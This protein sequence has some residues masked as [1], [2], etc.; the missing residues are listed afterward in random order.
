MFNFKLHKGFT[1]LETVIALAVLGM[2]FAATA[3][4]LQQV[5]V[6]IGQS[7]LQ[8]TA[9]SLGQ[10]KMETIRNLPYS[11]VGT[12][13][14]IPQGP[15]LQSEA[16]TTNGLVFTVT[17]SV[18][19]V[20]DPFDGLAPIDT[21]NNDYKRARVEVTWGGAY[22]SRQPVTLVSNI[23]PKGVETTAGGGTLIVQVFDS[24]GQ[25]VPAATVTVDNTVVAPAIHTQTLTS[26]LGILVLPGSPACVAC[27]KITVTKNNYSTDR[28]YATSE[29]ANPL[30]PYA[31]VIVSKVTQLSFAI[32]VVSTVIV[33][34]VNS[35]YQP[36]TNVQF[37]LRG[38]KI[39]GYTALDEPVYK[40]T[41]ATNTGGGTVNIPALEWDNYTLDFSNSLYN[42]SGSNPVQPFPLPP[43]TNQTVTA[44][45]TPK[46]ST[47]LL[48][49]V[50]NNA[51]ELQ[52]SASAELSNAGIGYDTTKV[53]PA[54]ASA[55]FGQV[56]FGGLTAGTY[57]LKVTLS[58]YQDSTSSSTLTTT[59][60]EN[61]VLNPAP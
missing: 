45:V 54:T 44:V 8:A 48:V 51:G 34:S 49:V 40:Y 11:Q 25:P 16:V 58:G 30:Q 9:L 56:F 61:I 57:N 4:M 46:T 36:Q 41:F 31:T 39:V 15:L 60:Q 20:D 37:T 10:A 28:T 55:D 47:S 43:A 21:I 29:V 12:A 7:R 35:A 1:L 52:S 32:D 19:Y 38:G 6:E 13:G 59:H 2:F 42:L 26:A 33:N 27:Y 17:T 18:V 5:L 14:G 3:Y 24:L 22:P 23:S 50:K 53:T